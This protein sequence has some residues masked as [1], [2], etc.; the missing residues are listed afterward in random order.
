MKESNF[1]FTK[2]EQ[3]EYHK[4]VKRRAAK[5]K[6]KVEDAHNLYDL[7]WMANKD[8]RET[9]KLNKMDRWFYNFTKRIEIIVQGKNIA[10]N[11]R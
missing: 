9:L 7:Y 11:K 8:L 10:F 4:Q 1:K 2:K 3:I 6:L 5:F